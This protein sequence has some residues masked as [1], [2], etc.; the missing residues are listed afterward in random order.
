ML[1]FE[2]FTP[3]AFHFSIGEKFSEGVNFGIDHPNLSTR[4]DVNFLQSE[5][6]P[7]QSRNHIAV[8]DEEYVATEPPV[9]PY[10]IRQ[11]SMEPFQSCP[12]IKREFDTT[13][14]LH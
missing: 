1:M 5:E 4:F 9:Y 11:G 3:C 14:Y 2:F 7:E 12:Y 10:F 6:P 8:K 13:H